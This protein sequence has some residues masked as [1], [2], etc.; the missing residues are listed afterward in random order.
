MT[1]RRLRPDSLGARRRCKQSEEIEYEKSE[2]SESLREAELP[3]LLRIREW[4][5]NGE[6][7]Q[8]RIQ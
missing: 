3:Q 6:E 4:L 2:A 8:D 7:L 5:V 1:Y